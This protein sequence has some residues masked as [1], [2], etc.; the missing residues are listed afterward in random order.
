M[1]T[2]FSVLLILLLIAIVLN[3]IY[4]SKKENEKI[5]NEIT[6]LKCTYCNKGFN[7]KSKFKKEHYMAPGANNYNLEIT[8]INCQEKSKYVLFEDGYR[9]IDPLLDCGNCNTQNSDFFKNH[10][11][12]ETCGSPLVLYCEKHNVKYDKEEGLKN[13]DLTEIENTSPEWA[14]ELKEIIQVKN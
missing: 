9:F 5:R 3:S 14:K 13:C 4:F 8:C 7:N 12:C 10:G 11:C 1:I 6:K 2:F